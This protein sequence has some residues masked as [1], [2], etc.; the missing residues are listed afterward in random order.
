M[1]GDKAVSVGSGGVIEP[2]GVIKKFSRTQMAAAVAVSET[3]HIEQRGRD[4]VFLHQGLHF[5][6]PSTE[7]CPMPVMEENQDDL[8]GRHLLQ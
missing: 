4:V 6:L 2:G 7:E 3:D 5:T 8:P 1:R